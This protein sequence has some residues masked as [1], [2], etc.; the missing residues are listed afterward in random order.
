MDLVLEGFD[1][2]LVAS[3]D[4]LAA[5]LQRQG[6]FAVLLDLGLVG[7]DLFAQLRDQLALLACFGGVLS[8]QFLF[9]PL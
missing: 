6:G 3:R 4:V 9:L 5:L 8:L 2:L 1:F 7:T